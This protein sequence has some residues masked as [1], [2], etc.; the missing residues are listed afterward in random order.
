[1]HTYAPIQ[2]VLCSLKKSGISAQLRLRHSPDLLTCL[3]SLKNSK[4][5][6]DSFAFQTLIQAKISC[7]MLLPNYAEMP[8]TFSSEARKI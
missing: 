6:Q 1:M 7:R 8:F 3:C 5:I 2:H 4:S